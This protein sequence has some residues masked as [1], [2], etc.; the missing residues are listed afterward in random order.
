MKQKLVI[1]DLV[2]SIHIASQL[3]TVISLSK[4]PMSSL[5]FI[6]FTYK[7][8]KRVSI[9]THPWNADWS[10]PV[11]IVIALIVGKLEKV[12][13]VCNIRVIKNNLIPRRG[14]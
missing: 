6:S 11:V 14:R 3:N 2:V 1:S 12:L 10:I 7:V 9:L 5:L 8:G 4:T 13:G